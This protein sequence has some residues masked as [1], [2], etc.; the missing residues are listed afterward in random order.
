[1]WRL[2]RKR[3]LIYHVQEK[4]RCTRSFSTVGLRVVIQI[5]RDVNTARRTHTIVILSIWLLFRNW[6]PMQE[7][8]SFPATT[9]LFTLRYYLG[10]VVARF[11]RCT[12]RGNSGII[13]LPRDPPWKHRF[14]IEENNNPIFMKETSRRVRFFYAR[15]I[16]T[17][18]DT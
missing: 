2:H 9:L 4:V 18:S 10:T 15:S 16:A 7:S 11:V 3:S 12:Y 6:L 5:R 17:T 8:Y 1:M 13:L 14:I